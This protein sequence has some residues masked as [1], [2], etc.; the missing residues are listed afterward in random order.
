MP[1]DEK[2]KYGRVVIDNRGSLE[3]TE[4]QVREIWEKEI[5][6]KERGTRNEERGF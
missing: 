4:Q 2:K 6:S 3:E 5:R 1:M